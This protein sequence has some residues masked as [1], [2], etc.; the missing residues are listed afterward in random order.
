NIRRLIPHNFLLIPGVGAQG[1][2]LESVCKFGM[3]KQC[4]LLVNSSRSI[5][6]ADATEKFAEAAGEEAKKLQ[7]EMSRQLKRI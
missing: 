7:I 1:G 4:G 5:I 6:Y 2:D 3:T